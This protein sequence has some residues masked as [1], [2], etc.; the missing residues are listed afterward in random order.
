[1]P[2]GSLYVSGGEEAVG[3]IN[4]QIAAAA[5][6]GATIVY[7]QDWHPESTPHFAKDGGI[8]PV[9]CVADSWGAAFH[10]HLDVIDGPVIHKGSGGEDGYSAFT[11]RDPVTAEETPTGLAEELRARGIESVV[12]VG[13]ATDYCIK[14]TALDGVR[15]GFATTVLAD[16]IRA[17]NLAPRDGARAVALMA[18]TGITVF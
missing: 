17:V 9:H 8:W 13:L 14:E 16:G 18:S 6:A 15:L 11:V 10:D 2:D 7:T 1:H 5:D 4:E 3:F 12:V